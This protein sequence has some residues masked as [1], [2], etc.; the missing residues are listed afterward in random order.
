MSPMRGACTL[1]TSSLRA[2]TPTHLGHVIR[3]PPRLPQ[4]IIMVRPRPRRVLPTRHKAPSQVAPAR[5]G[6]GGAGCLRRCARARSAG[7]ACAGLSA[8]APA[9]GSGDAPWLW[10]SQDSPGWRLPFPKARL[11]GA[12]LPPGLCWRLHRLPLPPLG[13]LVPTPLPRVRCYPLL[14]LRPRRPLLLPAQRQRPLGGAALP[15][16]VGRA[17]LP[18]PWQRQLLS[19]LQRRTAMGAGVAACPAPP[20]KDVRT[21]QRPCG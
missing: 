2:A 3:E 15:A 11:P 19:A 4:Q 10:P 7:A 21:N 9:T 16:A 18:W 1:A 17:P 6:H 8:H 12:G 20:P 5:L 14:L 13:S